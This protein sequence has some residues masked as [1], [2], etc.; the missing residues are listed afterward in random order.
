[1]NSATFLTV[2][3]QGTAFSVDLGHYVQSSNLLVVDRAGRSLSTL[4][5]ADPFTQVRSS[6]DGRF[7]LLA[8]QGVGDV[9]RFDL[10]RGTVNRLTF[11]AGENETPM[12][13]PDGRSFAYACVRNDKRT[14]VIRPA[15]GSSGERSVWSGDEHVHLHSWTPDGKTLIGSAMGGTADIL[16]IAVEDGQMKPFLSTPFIEDEPV[17][18]PDGSRLAY[19]SN[20][21]GKSEVYVRHWPAGGGSVQVSV[22]GGQRPHWSRNGKELFYNSGKALMA[23]AFGAGKEF[24]PKKPEVLFEKRMGDFDVLPDG[25]FVLFDTPPSVGVS[26]VDVTENWLEEL[27]R[28]APASKSN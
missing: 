27:K 2:D 18:S 20:E 13:S 16:S 24:D 6:P 7:L 22:D 4:K 3:D 11:E 25:K 28:I 9:K 1:M 12:W 19:R 23:V 10:E 15:D 21:S 26:E 8:H 17:I 14:I 5:I